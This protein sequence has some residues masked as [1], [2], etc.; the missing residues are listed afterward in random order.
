MDRMDLD[1]TR[2]FGESMELTEAII[3]IGVPDEAMYP[4]P[5]KSIDEVL[6]KR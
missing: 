2:S 1:N 4:R 5:R 6:V 3:A